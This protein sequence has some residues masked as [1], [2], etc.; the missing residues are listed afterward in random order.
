MWW[1]ILLLYVPYTNTLI[2]PTCKSPLPSTSASERIGADRTRIVFSTLFNSTAGSTWTIN[3]NW[4]NANASPCSYYGVTCDTTNTTVLKL[5]L[6]NNNLQG[7]IPVNLF[8]NLTDLTL[9][10]LGGNAISGSIPWMSNAR[11]VTYM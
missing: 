10:D 8:N 6:R 9:I 5:I 3:T 1:W 7:T 2:S 4:Q 11:A